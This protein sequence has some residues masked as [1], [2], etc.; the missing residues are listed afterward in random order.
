MQLRFLFTGKTTEKWIE[1]GCQEYLQRL[2][3]YINVECVIIPAP[4]AASIEL[5]KHKEF[6]LILEK[7]TAKDAIIL[8][9]E[10][11][12]EY[13]SSELATGL[14]KM[15]QS[16]KSSV[17][18]IVG[19]AYGSDPAL[20]KQANLVL[21]LSKL[22]FTHQMVRIFLLEQVYRAFTILKNQKYHH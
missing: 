19:G 16:G 2:K 21:S 22:T 17:T 11:G 12:K 1:E 9:D 8:L 3:K 6:K 20:F 10:K 18:F 4:S 5:Q 15:M 13:S 7:V 14:N